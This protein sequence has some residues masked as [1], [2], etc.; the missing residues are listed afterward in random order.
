ML[1]RDDMVVASGKSKHDSFDAVQTL[2]IASGQAPARSV[3]RLHPRKLDEA[4]R[5]ANLVETVVEPRLE[6]VV[7]VG[8]ASMTIPCERCHAVRAEQPDPVGELWVIGH[9]EPALTGWQILVRE[10]AEAADA[11]DRSALAAAPDCP[12][13]MRGVLDDRQPVPLGDL[14]DRLHVARIAPVMQDDERLRRRS[15]RRLEIDGGQIEV[16][17]AA[18]VA[19]IRPCS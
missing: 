4:D 11:A 2:A 18:D 6:D 9:N 7:R 17:T 16:G 5:R 1:R 15:D 14:Q 13:S 10:K 19:E 12:G 8:M 3:L